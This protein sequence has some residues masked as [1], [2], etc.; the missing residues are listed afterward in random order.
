MLRIFKESYNRNILE[1]P[2][3]ERA[4]LL[5]SF[6]DELEAAGKSGHST[7]EYFDWLEAHGWD[8]TKYDS[9][10]FDGDWDL[11]CGGDLDDDVEEIV[12]YPDGIN[13]KE[14]AWE[15]LKDKTDEYGNTYFFPDAE[16]RKLRDLISRFGNTYFWH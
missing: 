3:S 16:K 5:L 10:I 14:D 13:T 7:Q 9:D 8:T 6:W 15:W 4:K 12:E 11:A 1:I 2:A